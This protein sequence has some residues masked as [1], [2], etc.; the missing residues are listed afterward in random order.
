MQPPASSHILCSHAGFII[1]YKNYG[2]FGEP[3]NTNSAYSD[4]YN[5]T[6]EVPEVPDAIEKVVADSN[7]ATAEA[8]KKIYNL[9]GQQV[10]KTG[11]GI[12]IVGG[13][14]IILK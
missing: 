10:Q 6:V 8:D 5:I 13:K 1:V 7:S 9:N 14:K 12:Y 2:E 4:I 11:K 3:N